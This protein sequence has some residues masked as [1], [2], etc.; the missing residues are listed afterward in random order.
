MAT[1]EME[2]AGIGGGH[3]GGGGFT[4]KDI[5]SFLGSVLLQNG[6]GDQVPDVDSVDLEGPKKAAV[7]VD[8]NFAAII[9][10][11]GNEF[12]ENHDTDGPNI[13]ANFVSTVMQLAVQLQYISSHCVE[14]CP[15]AR[16]WRFSPVAQ[17]AMLWAIAYL[18]SKGCNVKDTR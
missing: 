6:A 17:A 11:N 4:L 12:T 8:P 14:I 13:P 9:N 7:M 15:W 2:E 10:W 3:I 1:K 16:M 5:S 18:R